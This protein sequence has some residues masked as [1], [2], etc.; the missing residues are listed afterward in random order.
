MPYLNGIQ[1]AVICLLPNFMEYDITIIPVVLPV[2]DIQDESAN[3]FIM[4][5]PVIATSYLL[6]CKVEG[7][8]NGRVYE[9]SKEITRAM[10]ITNSGSF[11]PL[12]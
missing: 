11:L 2:R 10:T 1:I 3:I 8:Q 7:C 4:P 9:G 6:C 5:I 12:M